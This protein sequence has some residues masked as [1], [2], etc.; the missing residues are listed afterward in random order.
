MTTPYERL[1][2]EEVPTGTFG[3]AQPPHA[4][5]SHTRPAPTWTPTQQAQHRTNLL[6]ALNNWTWDDD[7]RD[8]ER[9]HLRLIADQ[10]DTNAA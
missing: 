10:N 3:H 8:A 1:A 2:A 6:A 7:A 4:P 5:D 9:R